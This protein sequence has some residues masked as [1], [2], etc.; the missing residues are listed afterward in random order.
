M[1][2]I[3][4]SFQMLLQRLRSTEQTR[5]T[6]NGSQPTCAKALPRPMLF[7]F[8]SCMWLSVGGQYPLLAI[9]KVQQLLITFE[10]SQLSSHTSSCCPSMQEGGRHLKHMEQHDWHSGY[11]QEHIQLWRNAQELTTG[12][13]HEKDGLDR[14]LSST[15]LVHLCSWLKESISMEPVRIHTSPPCL[16]S[17]H[18]ALSSGAERQPDLTHR[19]SLWIKELAELAYHICQG[20]TR[21]TGNA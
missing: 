9:Q 12:P 4:P 3:T 18:S 19:C 2:V 5:T 20:T 1:E 8:W 15:L 14:P 21:K 10:Y 16:L 6:Q 11:R 17:W 13:Q 7:L